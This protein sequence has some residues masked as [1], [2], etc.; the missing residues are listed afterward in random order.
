MSAQNT[1]EL[2]SSPVSASVSSQLTSSSSSAAQ[3][4]SRRH[5]HH[6]RNTSSSLV[7]SSLPLGISLFALSILACFQF[8]SYRKVRKIRRELERQIALRQEERIGRIN[9]EKKVR[10]EGQ[11]ILLQSSVGYPLSPIGF[12]ESPFP[13]RRGI[14]FSLSLFFFLVLL[15]L[16][17]SIR[18]TSSTDPRSFRTWIYS[19]FKENHSVCTF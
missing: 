13:D 10:K 17:L 4:R 16:F 5:H 12:I 18:D 3:P 9:V 6:H 1:P 14:Q 8:Q 11:E 2:F 7:S 19:F 15:S